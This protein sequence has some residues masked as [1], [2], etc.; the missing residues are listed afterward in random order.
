MGIRRIRLPL[1]SLQN[2]KQ[3]NYDSNFE[4]NYNG[5]Q[6]IGCLCSY[7]TYCSLQK[8]MFI[9]YIIHYTVIL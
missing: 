1:Y 7:I 2:R 8:L 6:E 9:V 5:N 3:K 4:A